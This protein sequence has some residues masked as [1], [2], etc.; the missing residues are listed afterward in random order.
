MYRAV[1]KSTEIIRWLFGIFVSPTTL[2]PHARS[3]LTNPWFVRSPIPLGSTV[4]LESTL[5]KKEGRKSFISCKV[6]STDGSKVHTETTGN[7]SFHSH[8]TCADDS[9]LVTLCNVTVLFFFHHC[10]AALFLSINISHLIKS[11]WE[12]APVSHLPNQCGHSQCWCVSVFFFFGGERLF[13]R[14]VF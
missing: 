9:M 6:T 12:N 11:G 3:T 13:K 10:G 4:M 2:N 14:E 1:E 7:R 8:S 5:D